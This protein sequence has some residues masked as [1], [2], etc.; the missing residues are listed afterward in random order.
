M[1]R[2]GPVRTG[3]LV[4]LGAIA[5]HGLGPRRVRAYA[6]VSPPPA[7]VKRPVLILFDGQN[8]F[9]DR[10]SFAGGWHADE[11]ADTLGRGRGRNRATAP[12]V[13]GIDHGGGARLDELTPFPVDVPPQAQSQAH[14]RTRGGKLDAL[15]RA[16]VDELLPRLHAR[17]DLGYGPG[18]HFVGGASLGGLAALY[19]HFHRPDVF[20]GAIA[21]SPSLWLT[22]AR[23]GAFVRAQS[24]PYR[25]RVYLDAGAEEGR[26]RTF[27]IVKELAD[28][29]ES[30]GWAP[31]A[32]RRP[33]RILLQ[34]DARGRHDE[35]SWR[36]RLPKALRFVCEP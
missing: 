12:L 16:V 33:L 32:E 27:P 6:P 29:L 18:H 7:G 25:S 30:R 9:D 10:G 20:G 23:V 22:R 21:M 13:V 8:V 31:P 15:V 24:V 14:A 19:T 3:Q 1:P 35:R 17:F 26:G 2:S 28:H 34:R 5:P 4:D 36:R 11:A